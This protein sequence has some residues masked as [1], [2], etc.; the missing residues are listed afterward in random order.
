MGGVSCA[1]PDVPEKGKTFSYSREIPCYSGREGPFEVG[2]VVLQLSSSIIIEAIA[3]KVVSWSAPQSL[4]LTS[5]A[6]GGL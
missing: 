6:R 3:N 5:D 1:P 2:C 4:V